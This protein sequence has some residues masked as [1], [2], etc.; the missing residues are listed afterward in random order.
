MG[1]PSRGRGGVLT[2]PQDMLIHAASRPRDD[3]HAEPHRWSVEAADYDA[4]MAE[5]RM[6]VPD[7]W[8]LM[9]VRVD[10]A[11]AAPSGRR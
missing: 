1:R 9:Y 4:G 2:Y 3:P 11:P 6:A 10:R 5:I 7:G 8:V